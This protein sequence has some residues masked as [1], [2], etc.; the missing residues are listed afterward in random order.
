MS[1]PLHRRFPQTSHHHSP[2]DGGGA[3]GEQCDSE[4]RG[5]QQQWFA[6]D[7]SLE[8]GRGGAVWCR[9][10]NLRPVSGGRAHLHHDAP[11][12]ECQLHWWG[13]LPVCGLQSLRLQ[14][15]QQG[16]A[17]CQWWV[18]FQKKGID[19]CHC[20]WLVFPFSSKLYG[21]VMARRVYLASVLRGQCCDF[22]RI[23]K[24][25]DPQDY[26]SH[27]LIWHG[28]ISA[29]LSPSQSSHLFLRLPWT[30]LSGPGQWPGWSALPKVIPHPRLLGR[31]TEAQT[32]LPPESEGCTW[33]RMMTSS[34]L[35]TWRQ[36]TWEFTAARLR[37]QLV[38]CRQTPLSP[39]WVSHLSNKRSLLQMFYH[40]VISAESLCWNWLLV[41]VC[42][43]YT[44]TVSTS[45][46]VEWHNKNN[47]YDHIP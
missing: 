43:H 33:C 6:N 27:C 37:M 17:Y 22:Q 31:R 24:I 47:V 45:D 42:H 19:G 11:P 30:W 39:S 8:E 18:S 21:D 26:C 13:A 46:N 14:L 16:Q 5:H 25:A 7:H 34:S 36:K 15:L 12:P 10:A 4:L 35:P 9:S 41:Y 29:S 32:F 20:Q 2:R 40:W 44:T 1:L 38:A 23:L 28:Y 3:A